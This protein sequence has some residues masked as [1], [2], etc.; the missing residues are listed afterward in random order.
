MKNNAKHNLINGVSADYLNVNDRAIQYGDGLFETI[1]FNNN[2]LYYWQQHFQR[3]QDSCSRLKLNCPA[4]SVL[5]NDIKQLVKKISCS[6][7]NVYAIKIIVTRGV[8]GRGYQFAAAEKNSAATENR[9][10]SISSLAMDYSSLVSGHL[11]SGSLY[12][13]KQ[14][15]SI[16]QGLAGI[17]HLNRLENVL[18]RNEW[19][20]TDKA[21][22]IID[23]LMSNANQHVIE[24]CMSN[25][26]AVN[27]QQ[28]ITPDLALSGVNGV[29]RNMIIDLAKK[30]GILVSIVD[31]AMDELLSMD[32][33]FI[34][35]S[36]IGMKS[37]SQVK[38]KEFKQQ[39]VTNILFNDLLVT[40]NDYAQ[41]I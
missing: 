31:L 11:S 2:K 27:K 21:K 22:N 15:V 14:Q 7:Q 37:V 20:A 39:N 5:L 4:E 18:A 12:V 25:L 36:L 38:Q 9:I 8:S 30:N 13:C 35:N 6:Q 23:G 16:N 24:G 41:T 17:K 40:K 28:L 19:S 29:M 3:L 33:V 1:L 10:V 34:S 32:E 26:F